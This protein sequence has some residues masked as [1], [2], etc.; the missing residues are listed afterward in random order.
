MGPCLTLVRTF[1]LT[2]DTG[3]VDQAVQTQ[4]QVDDTPP[5]LNAVAFWPLNC[6]DSMDVLPQPVA[7]DGCNEETS[8][9]WSD[10]VSVQG[11]AT[12]ASE[13]IRTYTATDAC[14]NQSTASTAAVFLDSIPPVW[15]SAA[16]D[17]TV[18]CESNMDVVL[19]TAVDNCSAVEVAW[20][21][22][23]L[24]LASSGMYTVLNTFLAS[25]ACGNTAIHTQ[26]VTHVD[27]TP[28]SWTFVP[29]DTSVQCG[30][31]IPMVLP[32]ATDN[33]SED[34]RRGVAV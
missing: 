15:T 23:T 9:T 29:A 13:I 30:E 34:V 10:D 22:D 25:D 5:V 14:G 33:C 4:T 11:C 19:P 20:F 6:G 21:A 1:S 16:P 27:A 7:L 18:N 26:V 31:A 12:P 32:Q 2:D 24:G 28:P 8:L 17:T 3:L